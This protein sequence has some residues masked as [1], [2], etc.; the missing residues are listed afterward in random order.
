MGSGT[1]DKNGYPLIFTYIYY[2][3]R[4]AEV[5]TAIHDA[6]IPFPRTLLPVIIRTHPFNLSLFTAAATLDPSIIERRFHTCAPR[7]FTQYGSDEASYVGINGPE[8]VIQ[9]NPQ[10]Y[11]KLSQVIPDTRKCVFLLSF[12]MKIH[13]TAQ[14][15]Q[16]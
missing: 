16:V 11:E 1:R 9:W 14:A 15:Q 3:A 8:D 10:L 5:V 4:T 12:I 2:R 7:E 13:Y 6:G